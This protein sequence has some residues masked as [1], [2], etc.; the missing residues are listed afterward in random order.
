MGGGEYSHCFD[1]FI[2]AVFVLAGG[3]VFKYR[4]RHDVGLDIY[5]YGG[6]TL[7]L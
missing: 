6:R 4:V 5:A 1:C 3:S 7:H 2:F